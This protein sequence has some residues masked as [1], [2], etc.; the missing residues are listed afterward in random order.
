M[1]VGQD[2][3]V[4]ADLMNSGWMCEVGPARKL[5]FETVD[6]F[7]DERLAGGVAVLLAAIAVCE[8]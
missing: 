3:S 5:T 7:T 4:L 6:V 1:C 8:E 2:R